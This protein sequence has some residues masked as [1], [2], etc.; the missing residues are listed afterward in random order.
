MNDLDPYPGNMRKHEVKTEAQRAGEALK[1]LG[2]QMSANSQQPDR[3]PLLSDQELY[4]MWSL[5]PDNYKNFHFNPGEWY[6]LKD[7]EVPNDVI[8]EWG[9]KDVRDWYEAKITSGELRVVV[10]VQHSAVIDVVPENGVAA[11]PCCQFLIEQG[12]WVKRPWRGFNF[13]PGCG[14]KII[15]E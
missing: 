11:M 5:D 10:K 6:G 9:A 12:D 4:E 7:G 3:K 1:N 13:C 14:A 2:K 8:W 15:K